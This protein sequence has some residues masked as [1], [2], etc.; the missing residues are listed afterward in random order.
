M[1][2]LVFRIAALLALTFTFASGMVGSCMAVAI[3]GLPGQPRI[4]HHQDEPDELHSSLI[5]GFQGSINLESSSYNITAGELWEYFNNKGITSVDRLTFSVDSDNPLLMGPLG[6]LRFQIE[7]PGTGSYLT[8]VSVQGKNKLEIPLDYD[9]MKRFSANSQELIRLELPID[10]PNLSAAAISIETDS[11]LFSR[12]NLVLFGAFV[13]FWLGLFYLLNRFTKPVE[14]ES[15]DIVVRSMAI[16]ASK[17]EPAILPTH[18]AEI[19]VERKTKN[20]NLASM[21]E[22]VV[23]SGAYSTR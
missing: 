23:K 3:A 13:G 4:C 19:S 11:H 1:V 9:Y 5:T 20:V 22:A 21:S 15:E 18:A 10:S 6:S 16:E 8:N 17:P 7:D 2:R 12:L 14:E